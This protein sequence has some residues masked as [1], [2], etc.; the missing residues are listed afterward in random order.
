MLVLVCT[1]SYF[2]GDGVVRWGL[3]SSCRLG[4]SG[5]RTFVTLEGK[6]EGGEDGGGEDEEAGFGVECR[7]ARG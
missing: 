1:E 3:G 6:I 4:W 7:G 5:R 2:R